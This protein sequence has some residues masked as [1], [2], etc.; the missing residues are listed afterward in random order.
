MTSLPGTHT[1]GTLRHEPSALVSKMA[2]LYVLVLPF[3]IL[4]LVYGKAIT[5]PVSLILIFCWTADKIRWRARIDFPITVGVVM[6]LYL[7]WILATT[8]W[9]SA[10]GTTFGA[11]ATMAAQF[12]LVVIL[13]DV[14]PDIWETALKALALGT[15]ALAL[16]L[17]S[18]PAN[19]ERGGRAGVG[20]DENVTAMTLTI[21]FAAIMYLA[22]RASRGWVTGV[23]FGLVLLVGAGS[24]H[25]GSRTGFLA[26]AAVL[27]IGILPA[28]DRIGRRGR[29]RMAVRG[30]VLVAMSLAFLEVA[31]SAGMVPE[32]ILSSFQD[33][34][35]FDDPGRSDI[36]QMY[37][38]TISSWAFAGVGF[39]A[40]AYYLQSTVGAFR[41]AHNLFWKTWIEGGAV[42]LT[43][44]GL[45]LW[46]IAK[47]GMHSPAR[48][49][50]LLFA[51]PVLLFAMTL[52]GQQNNILWFV[53]ALALIPPSAPCPS[54][55]SDDQLGSRDTGGRG[56]TT[57]TRVTRHQA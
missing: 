34:I 27:V 19:L 8:V 17:L 7:F 55:A 13:V 20:V 52:G 31:R 44:F 43:L 12:L 54:R 48:S 47:R 18:Q 39:G 32:R 37:L 35:N 28:R 50:L 23:Y 46:L 33:A 21:G 38:P 49:A 53:A 22:V 51:A 25:V 29:S 42:S 57:P 1:G 36:V 2:L 16:L 10:P 6:Y 3:D 41:N 24:V 26:V 45:L 14:L 30:L 9:S 15:V 40:D 56:H 11:A 4:P 5:V